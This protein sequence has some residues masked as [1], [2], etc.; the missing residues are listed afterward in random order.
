MA[1]LHI[2]LMLADSRPSQRTHPRSETTTAPVA[3][4]VPA[5]SCLPALQGGTGRPSLDPAH[6]RPVRAL[7]VK[8]YSRI[9][10]LQ[11]TALLRITIPSANYV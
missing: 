7:T 5:Y 10:E 11:L 2:K 8:R 1:F 6:G 4:H 3:P 9:A